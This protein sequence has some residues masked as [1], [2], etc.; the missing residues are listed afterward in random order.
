MTQAYIPCVLYLNG[1]YWGIYFL[2][3]KIDEDYI[4]QHLNVSPE[5]VTLLR[6]NWQTIYGDND[7]YIG[8]YSY[9]KKLDMTVAKNYRYVCSKI[10]IDSY[11]DY[12]IAQAYLGNRDVTNVKFYK[13][14]ES[15]GKWRWILFDLDYGFDYAYTE[16]Y[17]TLYNLIKEEG[18]GYENKINNELIRALL[19]NE[20]FLDRFLTRYGYW[21]NTSFVEENVI[22]AIDDMV[23]ML[24]SEQERNAIRW[25]FKMSTYRWYVSTLKDFVQDGELNRRQILIEEARTLFNL[26]DEQVA[27]YFYPEASRPDSWEGTL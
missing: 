11:I 1:E 21:L 3:E 27:K 13:S 6:G 2:R 16:H 15:D 22:S 17:Y 19:K 24:A 5:S 7:E 25:N 23:D 4:S 14:T 18:T 26:T 12:Y 9:A 10:D 8:F 20:E